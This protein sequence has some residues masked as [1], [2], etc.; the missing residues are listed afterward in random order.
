MQRGDTREF[1]A[2]FTTI[3]RIIQEANEEARGADITGTLESIQVMATHHSFGPDAFLPWL[4]TSSRRAW[5]EIDALWQAGDGSLAGVI[6]FEHEA[7]HLPPTPWWHF[8]R[9]G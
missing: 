2:A 5:S 4:G 8:W 6:R 3:E 9:R 1:D 7:R